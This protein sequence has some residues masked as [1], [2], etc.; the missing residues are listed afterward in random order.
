MLAPGTGSGTTVGRSTSIALEALGPTARTWIGAIHAHDFAAL[1]AVCAPNV[2]F[3]ALV[4]SG[5]REAET[6]GGAVAWV[7]RWFGDTDSAEILDAADGTV[8]DRTWFTYRFHLRKPAGW[9]L[10]EQQV[11]AT[12]VDGRIERLDLLCS[13]F[14][15][16]EPI[17]GRQPPAGAD[18]LA[19]GSVPHA[20]LDALG[21]SCSTLIPSLARTLAAVPVGGVLDILTDDP[22]AE[23]SLSS[24]ARLTGNELIGSR[25]DAV[26]GAHW[27]VR[28]K[29][30]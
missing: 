30:S 5:L 27:Y 2:A 14:R 16:A 19:G 10:I 22:T 24:W 11:Y 1:E 29:E 3:R 4:P 17:E 6:R 9:R 28:R 8:A 25:P 20:A 7:E 23:P 15:P 12:V 26:A 18:P 13:G 21:A